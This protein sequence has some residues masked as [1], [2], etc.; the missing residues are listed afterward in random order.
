MKPCFPGRDWTPACPWKGMNKFL[1]L[2][3]MQLW[4]L[5]YLLNSPYLDPW[6]CHF[7]DSL[8]IPLWGSE[9]VFVWGW[10]LVGWK[11]W[12]PLVMTWSNASARAGSPKARGAGF[13]SNTL[14]ASTR[15]DILKISRWSSCDSV[16]SPLQGKN[17]FLVFR[18]NLSYFTFSPLPLVL[19]LGST[20]RAWLHPSVW[21]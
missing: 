19:S 8:A 4:L 11:P 5:L 14:A 18:E 7:S 12:Q 2:F 16:W 13:S 3:H 20:E 6:V 17:V 1:G 9:T 21:R 10:A 15:T